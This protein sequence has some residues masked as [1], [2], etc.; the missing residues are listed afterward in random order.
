VNPA[1]C[2]L[3][4]MGTQCEVNR[5][6]KPVFTKKS[7]L[8]QSH[9]L[10][11]RRTGGQPKEAL[12]VQTSNSDKEK[13]LL[14][15][16]WF[17][18]EPY[19]GDK[20]R[21]WKVRCPNN[22]DVEIRWGTFRSNAE[23]CKK[24]RH[25]SLAETHPN[26]L[27]WWDYES[28]GNL[29]PENVSKGMD[30]KVTWRCPVGH[31]P[32]IMISS[33]TRKSGPGC[34]ICSGHEVFEG[35]NDIQ[36]QAPELLQFWDHKSNKTKPNKVYCRSQ[37]EMNWLCKND[38][39]FQMSPWQL[40]RNLVRNLKQGSEG[41]KYCAHRDVWS[42]WNDLKSVAPHL[43]S[44][45]Q[46]GNNPKLPNEVCAYTSE[47][48]WWQCER[49]HKP[50][51]QS[52]QS[53]VRRGSGCST[54]AQNI[55][56][57]GVNDALS[58]N[59]A[60]AGIWSLSENGPLDI[61]SQTPKSS[62]KSFRWICLEHGHTYSATVVHAVKG[63]SCGVCSKRELMVG[64]NDLASLDIGDEF[65]LEKTK[66]SAAELGWEIGELASDKIIQSEGRKVWW[67][68]KKVPHHSWATPPKARVNSGSG[69]LYCGGT[70][71]DVG[72][73][74]LATKFPD[75]EAEWSKLNTLKMSEVSFS[76]HEK[77]HWKCLAKRGHP[78]YL[79]A[80]HARTGV[81]N[82]G[83][84]D[85]NTGGFETSQ[86]AYLY[87][88]E[89]PDLDSCKIGISNNNSHP[90]RLAVWKSRGWV[91]VAVWEDPYGAVIKDTEQEVLRSF[92]RGVLS[93][94]QSLTKEEIGG[95]G[96]KETFPR[97]ERIHNAVKTEISRV[98]G[99]MRLHHK[100]RLERAGS[101]RKS[102]N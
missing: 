41:C 14:G 17:Y 38:H 24:C 53:R 56:E 28:N 18:R 33:M 30:V 37:I 101:K 86:P 16:G 61:L 22:H 66:K 9:Y 35:V 72:R 6:K 82:T 25:P 54:C 69:C 63:V 102:A 77:V 98:L 45:Y 21:Q 39:K 12:R 99:D 84:P 57:S 32:R 79:A 11:A 80:P 36:S 8:C 75:L 15:F 10:S 50:R 27:T 92:I 100:A 60:L 51:L 71:L 76:Q 70:R 40:K 23:P 3:D 65:D 58:A 73:N 74:D 46:R 31:S 88:I 52:P 49:L 87:F 19:P 83:C 90:N 13:M 85:C 97:I 89:H 1:K 81:N 78:D 95:N 68:C 2:N 47:D 44:D 4:S 5:C 48:Y 34:G 20:D 59:P 62:A 42:G 64:V 93:L 94:P 55:T 43:V 7:G 91:E 26:L 96:Q 67:K 29:S